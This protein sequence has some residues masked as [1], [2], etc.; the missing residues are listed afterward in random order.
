[1][2]EHKPECGDTEVRTLCTVEYGVRDLFG[3]VVTDDRWQSPTDVIDA[4][5][6]SGYTAF[7]VP[8]VI[9]RTTTTTVT[10]TGWE[11]AS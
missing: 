5:H 6:R 2:S 8:D 3:A 11:A 9:T 1:M 10:T 4:L 7:S